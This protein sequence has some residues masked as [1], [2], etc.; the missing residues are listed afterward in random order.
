MESSNKLILTDNHPLISFPLNHPQTGARRALYPINFD[1]S[2]LDNST[3]TF[4]SQSQRFFKGFEQFNC[5]TESE[6]GASRQVT[7]VYRSRP[8]EMPATPYKTLSQLNSPS[9]LP[10]YTP[11]KSLS[12]FISSNSQVSLFSEVVSESDASTSSNSIHIDFP[13]SPKSSE[14]S[15]RPLFQDG[16]KAPSISD[17]RDT[18][19]PPSCSSDTES[20]S[21]VHVPLVSFPA[22]PVAHPHTP[23]A[24]SQEEVPSPSVQTSASRQSKITQYRMHLIIILIHSTHWILVLIKHNYLNHIFMA[25]RNIT[26]YFYLI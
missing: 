18:P 10:P 8:P 2:S 12:S 11:V 22:T 23:R 17:P 13:S 20:S 1:D 19:S 14:T 4:L 7:E 26:N 21:L 5:I 16:S 15:P 6:I 24:T 9:K 25:K 3:S